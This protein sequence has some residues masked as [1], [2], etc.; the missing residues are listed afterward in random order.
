MILD[1]EY[2]NML[3]SA[4]GVYAKELPNIPTAKRREK[5]ITIPGRDGT[6][7]TS[8]GD[9]ESI[10]LTID[11]NFICDEEE[12][13][14]RWGAVKKWLS[15]RYRRLRL[16]T[17]P[18]H[19]YKVSKVELEDAEHTTARICNFKAKF[20]TIDGLRYL[21]E[22][23]NEHVAEDVR[24]N[25]YEVAHPIYMISGEGACV[26]TVNGKTMTADVGQNIT[27][28]TDRELAYRKDKTL[29]NTAVSG[30]Y[31]DLYLQEGENEITITEGFDLKIIPNWRC[32]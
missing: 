16:S 27:I 9:Y 1:V 32:L 22:G 7:F 24:Y 15:A 31:D 6:I 30:K 25:P 28:D 26:L 23:Q 4:M 12:W 13:D 20:T 11:F 2:N 14:K 29:S 19:F 5:E 8:Y 17:D 18:E 21:L 10:E 3:G